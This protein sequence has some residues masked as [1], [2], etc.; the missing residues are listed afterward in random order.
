[1]IARSA[2]IQ[3]VG[4]LK[5][6]MKAITINIQQKRE[7]LYIPLHWK[8][9]NLTQ[10]NL[11]K[12]ELNMP[13]ARKRPRKKVRVLKPE[14][15]SGKKLSGHMRG[16]KLMNNFFWIAVLPS[17]NNSKEKKNYFCKNRSFKRSHNLIAEI[18]NF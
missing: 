1:M 6:I 11:K 8:I 4:I 10:K 14:K 16:S 12:K 13:K 2:R 15:N 7:K 9:T 18:N 17:R 3:I 5:K